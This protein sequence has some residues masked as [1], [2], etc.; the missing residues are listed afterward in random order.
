MSYLRATT[1]DC[2]VARSQDGVA[3]RALILGT[4]H[5]PDRTLAHDQSVRVTEVGAF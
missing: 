3:T 1:G 5:R 2:Q 4:T